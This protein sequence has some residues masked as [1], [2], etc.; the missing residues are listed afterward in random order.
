MMTATTIPTIDVTYDA[1]PRSRA[2]LTLCG[3]PLDIARRANTLQHNQHRARLMSC[4]KRLQCLQKLTKAFFYFCQRIMCIV[5]MYPLF[6]RLS[7][8]LSVRLSYFA[9]YVHELWASLP[10]SKKFDSICT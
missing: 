10:D 8:C 3:V 4:N 7:A 2:S 6:I 1:L 5:M 9:S